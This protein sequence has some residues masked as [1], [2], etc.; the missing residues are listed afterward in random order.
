[1][2]DILTELQ[3]KVAMKPALEAKLRELKTRE[4][5]MTGRLFPSGL[6][7]VKNRKM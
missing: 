1:M 7:F 5:N 4:E 2:A 3:H 6:H